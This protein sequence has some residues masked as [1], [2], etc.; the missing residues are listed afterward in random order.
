MS[1]AV[2]N[3]NLITQHHTD[4]VALQMEKLLQMHARLQYSRPE[5]LARGSIVEQGTVDGL[6]FQLSA[7]NTRWME[8]ENRCEEPQKLLHEPERIKKIGISERLP[9]P[10]RFYRSFWQSLARRKLRQEAIFFR[11]TVLTGRNDTYL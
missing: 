2:P 7:T 10:R 4:S 1:S 11:S 8:P 9:A 3:Q 6:L 5:A